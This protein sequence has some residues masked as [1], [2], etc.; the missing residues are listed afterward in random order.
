MI[1]V[2]LLQA[3]LENTFGQNIVELLCTLTKHANQE[4]LLGFFVINTERNLRLLELMLTY[5]R[6]YMF[7]STVLT[8]FN[9]F[10]VSFFL[11]ILKEL[12]HSFSHA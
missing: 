1:C 9:N 12:F 4:L 11:L 8:V 2:C 6:F 7:A 3:F 5:V 10:K